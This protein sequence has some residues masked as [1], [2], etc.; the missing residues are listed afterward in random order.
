L[1]IG[2]NSSDLKSF[3]KNNFQIQKMGRLPDGRCLL[4][5]AAQ[6]DLLEF[7]EAAETEI[8]GPGKHG[9]SH[10]WLHSKE[11]LILKLNRIN[12]ELV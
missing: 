3:L 10:R 7:F 5:Q 9:E 8:I 11:G 12:R 2:F 1:H 6:K 4:S